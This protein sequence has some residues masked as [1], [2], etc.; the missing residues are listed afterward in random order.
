MNKKILLNTKTEKKLLLLQRNE[1]SSLSQKR[2]RKIFGRWLYTN[3]FINFFHTKDLES[4]TFLLLENEF[5]NLRN[6]FPNN[7][8]SVMDIGCGLGLINL[9]INNFYKNC[10][11]FYLLDKN[12]ID[13][14]IIYGHS[15]QYESYN[16]LDVTKNILINNGL[17]EQKINLINVD[18]EIKI[19]NNSI[20][21][22]ISLVSMGYHYPISNYLN[23][24]KEKCK[25]D[26]VIIFDIALE[27]QSLEYI[28][29]LF[30][31]VKIVNESKDITHPR[32]RLACRGFV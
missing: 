4:K 5:R 8:V 16:Y 32:L 24:L 22:C 28:K 13:N 14:K 25:S 21:L 27:Y 7:I 23:L 29:T 12:R 11:K 30:K 18:R 26:C 31:D 10:K 9:F 1:L 19:Q 2:I 3:L 20:D 6:F 15:S 17:E